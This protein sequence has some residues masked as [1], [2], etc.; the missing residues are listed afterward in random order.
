MCVCVCMIKEEAVKTILR[1]LEKQK[2]T[3][4][5]KNDIERSISRTLMLVDN[6]SIQKWFLFLFRLEC[7]YQ[8]EKDK[9]ILNV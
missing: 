2:K 7:I 1:E 6:R 3:F 9:F 5:T 4:Y 8:K